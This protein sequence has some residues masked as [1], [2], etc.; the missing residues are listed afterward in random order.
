[1]ISWTVDAYGHVQQSTDMSGTITSYHYDYA[2][3]LISQ[4]SATQQYRHAMIAVQS[5]T[6]A[7]GLV[8]TML[9][10]AI[11]QAANQNIVYTYDGN[12]LI[13]I[14]DKALDQQTYYGYDLAGNV[15]SEKEVVNSGLAIGTGKTTKVVQD[16]HTSYDVMGRV[17]NIEDSRYD[18]TYGYD[19]N[20]NR[21]HVETQYI[22]DAGS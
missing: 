16:N 11:A 17:Q 8:Q 3:H 20:G 2:G 22:D 9:Q 13:E 15:I 1:P 10:Q 4:T 19:G 7:N 14:N 21:I 5:S 18:V 6:P 12:R